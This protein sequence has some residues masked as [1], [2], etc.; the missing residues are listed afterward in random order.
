MI[1]LDEIRRARERLGDAVLRTPLVRF[2]DAHLAEAREPP[3]DRLVQ[4][5]RRALRRSVPAAPPSSPAASSRRAPGTWPRASRGLRARSAC[6]RA[7]SRPIR[8]RARSSTRSSGSA[9]RSSRVPY[10][11]WWQTMVDRG[12]E[13]LDGLFV[14]PVEDDAVM[15]G[16]GTIGLELCEDS[17]DVRHGDRPVGRRRAHDRH[18]ERREGAAPG[19]PR[20]HRGAGDGGAARSC[21]RRRR[22]DARSSSSRRSS[23]ARAAARCCRRCGIAHAGSSTRRLP[24]RSARSPRR[25]GCS[26]RARASSPRARVRSRSRPRVEREGTIVCIVSGGN[27][28]AAVLAR[29]LAG[30]TPSPN[31]LVTG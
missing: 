23:T 6:A 10:E 3:A 11:V 17:P 8:R 21:A 2:D 19:R 18:R 13:G 14:H 25:C 12:Y 20:R 26:R 15:A 30:E 16:N 7:S 31:R 4:A 28:D 1:P 22:A 5:A 24:F 27:I 9:A 29:I